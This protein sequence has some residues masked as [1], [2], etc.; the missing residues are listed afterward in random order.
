M[1]LIIKESNISGYN[2]RTKEN[3][4]MAGLTCAFACDMF[5]AGEMLT[6]K[7][8]GLKYLGF[9]ITRE[10]IADDSYIKEWSGKISRY[11]KNNKIEVINLAGNGIYTLV[12]YGISQDDIN[13][14]IYKVFKPI[15]LEGVLKKLISGGQTGVDIATAVVSTQLNIDCQLLFPKNFI[16]RNKLGEDKE[17]TKEEI[18]ILIQDMANNLNDRIH[19]KSKKTSLSL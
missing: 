1:N 10:N 8:A 11:V 18:L 6:K 17:H 16:Q 4:K 15:V 13:H 19:Q 14:L 9:E 12:K 3:A 7:S 5:T 2:H